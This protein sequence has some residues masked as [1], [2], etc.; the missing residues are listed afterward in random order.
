[1]ASLWDHFVFF[2]VFPTSPIF[3]CRQKTGHKERN[4]VVSRK[5]AQLCSM[6]FILATILFARPN[7]C[8]EDLTTWINSSEETGVFLGAYNSCGHPKAT[9][10][11]LTGGP[12][13]GPRIVD[14]V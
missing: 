7:S 12:N 6:A 14:I 1:M 9:I 8:P 11:A 13:T 3:V 2:T 5:E 10:V 4:T